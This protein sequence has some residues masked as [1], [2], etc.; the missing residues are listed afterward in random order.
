MLG[1]MCVPLANEPAAAGCS[2]LSVC[3]SV[4]LSESMA[5]K[6]DGC[7]GLQSLNPG[8]LAGCGAN[9]QAGSV[10]LKRY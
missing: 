8:R 10:H 9:L 7:F 5:K 6:Q 3:L 1:L 2:R 4:R